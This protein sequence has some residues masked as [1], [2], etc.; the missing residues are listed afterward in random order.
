VNVVP[1]GAS[2]LA[3]MAS[4]FIDGCLIFQLPAICSTTSLESILTSISASGAC[5]AASSS[6]AISPRYSA[7]LLVAT[8]ICSPRSA[9]TAPVSASFSR[10]P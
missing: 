5:S 8:P 10:A 9:I 1:I 2:R 4:G 6:P 3:S 7:T